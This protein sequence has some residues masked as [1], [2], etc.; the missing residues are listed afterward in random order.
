MYTPLDWGTWGN[1]GERG[2]N[3]AGVMRTIR[4]YKKKVME[5]KK[6]SF[7]DMDHI[8]WMHTST[9]DVHL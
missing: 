3:V 2:G 1:V 9:L 6:L 5:K 4:E 8:M 7:L